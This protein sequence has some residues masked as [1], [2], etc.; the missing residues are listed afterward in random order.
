MLFHYTLYVIMKHKPKTCTLFKSILSLSF[1][2]FIFLLLLHASNFMGSSQQDDCKRTICTVCL[3]IW[4]NKSE[5]TFP[6]TILLTTVHVNIPYKNCIYNCLPEDKAM[7]FETSR[8]RQKLKNWFFFNV[9][10]RWH[11]LLYSILFPVNGSTCFGCNI[12]PSS[13]ARIN[14]SYSIW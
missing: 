6:P 1:F 7:G 5:H 11:F 10:T 9:P 12:H 2:F 4:C 13:G 3:H 8:R 14:C